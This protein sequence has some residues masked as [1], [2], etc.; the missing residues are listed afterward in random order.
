MHGPCTWCPMPSVRSLSC[1]S[2]GGTVELRGLGRSLSVV[3]I[4]CLSVLD[5]STPTLQ[6]IQQFQA[7]QRF[8]PYIPLGTRGKMRG[9]LYEVIGFQVRQMIA[10]GVAYHWSEYT[11]FN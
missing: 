9:D 6:V 4:Q 5:A 11:L 1:P 8:Q 2:C 7:K 3:C 10:G